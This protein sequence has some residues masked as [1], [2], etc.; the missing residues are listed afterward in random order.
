MPDAGRPSE[1]Q[2]PGEPAT[3]DVRSAPL[4]P[5]DLPPA[6]VDAGHVD[7][8]DDPGAADAGHVDAGV[9][10]AAPATPPV[11][12]AGRL[13]GLLAAPDRRRVVAA[14]ILGASTVADIARLAELPTRAVVTALARLVDGE[15][16]LRGPEG[17]HFLVEQAFVEAARAAAPPPAPADAHGDAPAEAARVLRTF[18]RDG[19]LTQIPTQR[20]K[21]LVVLDRLAQEFEPGRR[22]SEPMVNLVLGR[23]HA[24]TAA[25]RRYLVDEGFLDRAEG[26]YWRSGG[27]F[28]VP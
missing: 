15:L 21:R 1:G 23:W 22:Y 14:L 19:R 4:G 2:A 10:D 11:V 20:S 25:L 7:V 6:H 24:D 17:T 9:A 26:Q 18:L 8:G 5:A 27:S 13:A 16:V 3:G 12:D 28:P